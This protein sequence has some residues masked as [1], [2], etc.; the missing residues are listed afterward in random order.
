[1]GPR[2]WMPALRA[3]RLQWN[4]VSGPTRTGIAILSDVEYGSDSIDLMNSISPIFG[5][6]KP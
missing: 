6:R 2:K 5:T 4:E 1:M 3:G